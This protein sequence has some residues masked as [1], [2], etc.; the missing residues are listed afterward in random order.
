MRELYV[1]VGRHWE[2]E[3]CFSTHSLHEPNDFCILVNR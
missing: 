3:G 2:E 1:K